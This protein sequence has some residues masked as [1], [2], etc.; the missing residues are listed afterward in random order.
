MMFPH[1]LVPLAPDESI[2]NLSGGN[3][4]KVIIARWLRRSPGVIVLDEPTQ[5]VDVGTKP[6]IYALLREVAGQGA[7]VIVCSTDSEE[8]VEVSTRAVVLSGGR[9]HAEFSGPTLTIDRINHRVV[10]A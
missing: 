1:M 2:L 9:V 3:Q 6:E 8:I 7:T 4:Q 10:V 5:G